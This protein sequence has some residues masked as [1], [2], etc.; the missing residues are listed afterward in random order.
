MG[1][2]HL[3]LFHQGP[4]GHGGEV[5][6]GGLD[7]GGLLGQDLVG[8]EAAAHGG[9]RLAAGFGFGHGLLGLAQLLDQLGLPGDQLVRHPLQVLNY[10]QRAV[11]PQIVQGLGHGNLREV[12]GRAHVHPQ[13]EPQV[14]EPGEIAQLHH[15]LLPLAALAV[16]DPAGPHQRAKAVVGGHHIQQNPADVLQPL[17]ESGPGVLQRHLRRGLEHHQGRGV[18]GP[19]VA[20]LGVGGAETVLGVGHRPVDDRE[21]LGRHIG[22]L[23][24]VGH[25]GDGLP[26]LEAPDA[27]GLADLVAP[28]AHQVGVID[29]L[30]KA[31]QL[32]MAHDHGE[33][34]VD[35][36]LVWNDPGDQSPAVVLVFLLLPV[37][38]GDGVAGQAGLHIL[39]D[40]GGLGGLGDP[41]A[42]VFPAGVEI[43]IEGL[44]P[45]HIDAAALPGHIVQVGIGLDALGVA[46]PLGRLGPQI[47]HGIPAQQQNIGLPLHLVVGGVAEHDVDAVHQLHLDLALDS[48]QRPAVG[49]G[50]GVEVEVGAVVA[51]LGAVE[52]GLPDAVLHLEFLQQVGHFRRGPLG[53]GG[54]AGGV[55]QGLELNRGPRGGQR[56][57]KQAGDALDNIKHRLRQPPHG[58]CVGHM[59]PLVALVELD[60]GVHQAVL[61]GLQLVVVGAAQLIELPRPGHG[62]LHAGSPFH[63]LFRNPLGSGA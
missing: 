2:S 20:H 21:N 47:L 12:A 41:D 11:L 46:A 1:T 5:L 53:V 39:V 32:E 9:G 15:G 4:L 55:G 52:E 44:V 51:G 58:R 23:E 50:L 8:A 26:R 36:D 19:D 33:H 18:V 43:D 49:P 63:V 54:G 37:A 60:I 22:G 34:G 24:V 57:H 16:G 25:L 38:P 62:V 3:P 45:G 7:A 42:A 17:V 30:G 28:P 27:D 56:R 6:I 14:P 35:K 10:V 61:V 40:H 31:H 29:G 13:L 59:E 48:G